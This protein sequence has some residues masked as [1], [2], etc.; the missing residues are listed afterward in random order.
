MKNLPPLAHR[1]VVYVEGYMRDQREMLA[2]Q[3]AGRPFV[4]ANYRPMNRGKGYWILRLE[5]SSSER[6][7]IGARSIYE[8]AGRTAMRAAKRIVGEQTVLRLYAH[9]GNIERRL[10]GR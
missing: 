10:T 5:P 2:A 9:L 6:L 1:A 3:L 7:K 4:I 8:N